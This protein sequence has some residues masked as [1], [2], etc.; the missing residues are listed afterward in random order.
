MAVMYLNALVA[1]IMEGAL[2][3][4]VGMGFGLFY[5]VTRIF[6]LAYGAIFTVGA[7]VAFQVA[8]T[9]QMG[10]LAGLVAGSVA[11]ALLGVVIDAF[12]YQPLT[13][14]GVD[15]HMLLVSGLGAN[16]VIISVCIMIWG[17]LLKYYRSSGLEDPLELGPI[18]II[19]LQLLGLLC[20]LGV[21]GLLRWLLSATMVGK[22]TRALIADPEVAVIIGVSPRTVRL[23]IAAVTAIVAAWGAILRTIG[24]GVSPNMDLTVLIT[25]ATAALLGRRNGLGSVLLAGIM[26][27]IFQNVGSIL[28]GGEWKTSIALIVLLVVLTMQTWFPILRRTRTG[29]GQAAQARTAPPLPQ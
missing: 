11:A 22:S 23:V 14:R 19:P 25:A 16:A 20:S 17:G 28:I 15:H 8:V 24:V 1:G 12:L 5:W 9:W 21:Y 29:G 26:L 18:L 2:I 13:R 27:G 7:Y 6:H 10:V 4:L 3:G